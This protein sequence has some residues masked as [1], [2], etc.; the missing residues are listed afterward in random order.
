MASQVRKN[1]SH[2][3]NQIT[4][5]H[6]SKRIHS[7]QTIQTRETEQEEHDQ[8][9]DSWS[10]REY[11]EEHRYAR[12]SRPSTA[13]EA[14]QK[15]INLVHQKV[16]HAPFYMKDLAV[17]EDDIDT[18]HDTN[19]NI[20]T[21]PERLPREYMAPTRFYPNGSGERIAKIQAIGKTQLQAIVPSYDLSTAETR[22]SGLGP[23][24]ET[25]SYP[26]RSRKNK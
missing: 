8:N 17:Y 11:G 20:D 25:I 10:F 24:L 1:R 19:Q 7:V 9:H 5:T 3:S 12:P 16:T 22:E 26:I 4:H 21:I 13:K 23:R 18:H 2:H 15:S 6:G 14:Y